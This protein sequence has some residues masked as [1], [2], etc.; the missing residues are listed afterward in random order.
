MIQQLTKGLMRGSVITLAEEFG[1]VMGQ[2]LAR[3][4]QSQNSNSS[5]PKQTEIV[6][7][8]SKTNTRKD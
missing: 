6:Y 1:F 2:T 4:V 5:T 7:E 3:Y 8:F